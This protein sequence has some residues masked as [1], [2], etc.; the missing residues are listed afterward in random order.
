[1]D[2][3]PSRLLPVDALRGVL[4]I[5]MALDHANQF[6]AQGK[7][8]PE[9]WVG[10]FPTYQ[11]E[12]LAFLTR[13]I[14]HLAAPGFFLLMGVGI[15]LFEISRRLAGWSRRQML[16]HFLARGLLLILLQFL[17]ENPAWNILE[18]FG[19]IQYF[20]VLFALG[21]TMIAGSLLVYLPMP[22]LIGIS[23]FLILST[24]LVLPE[25]GTV[26]IN[27]PYIMR[28][29]SVP[30]YSHGVYV[31]YPILPWLGVVGLGIAFGK[32]LWSDRERAYRGALWLGA[33]SLL[34]FIPIRFMDGF[35]NIRPMGGD[36]WID[37]L[38]VV[39]YPP[40][41]TF[42]LLTLGM[43]LVLLGGIARYADRAERI[44]GVLA[45]YG[46]VPLFFYLS[47]L[48][49]YAI[50]GQWIDPGGIGI[51]RMY[52]FWL[53]GLVLLYPLCLLFGRFKQARELNS[54]W[55]FL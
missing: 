46:C 41:T 42:L 18:I 52:P 53:V 45:V 50:M 48:Y 20:G 31:L 13:F 11:G 4:I 16:G 47:H 33:A 32:W 55:R 49:L 51:L 9:L 27:Y 23:S 7:H 10:R 21:G 22:W 29:F 17:I 40:S 26:N 2:N 34:L 15:A 38:N 44:M 35:G 54:L 28:I 43:N 19:P 25:T 24:E 3:S 36:Y 1:M 14:T 6:I 8:E 5:V 39:K 12:T 30:G 37:F